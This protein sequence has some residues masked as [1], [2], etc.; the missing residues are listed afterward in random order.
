VSKNRAVPA[1]AVRGRKPSRARRALGGFYET[2]R[3]EIESE[4]SAS[5][6]GL[7]QKIDPRAKLISALLL[8]VASSSAASPTLLAGS[9]I[10]AT[11]LVVA[12]RVRGRSFLRALAAPLAI[13][14]LIILPAVL[15]LVTPGRPLVELVHL[16]KGKAIWGAP[17]PD[18]IGVTAEGTLAAARFVLRCVTCAA[19]ASALVLT[20]R[21]VSLL[22]AFR[23]LRVPR[24]FTTTM[25]MMY[26]YTFAL[27]RHAEDMRLGKESRL[28]SPE[29]ALQA[30]KVVAARI[31]RLFRTAR[32]LGD[33]VYFAMA[34]RGFSGT[35]RSLDPLSLRSL[36]FA[37]AAA[38]VIA[39]VGLILTDRMIG[40]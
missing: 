6:P 2:V 17:L 29:R 19:W 15:N 9:L 7:L 20:T 5:K 18:T 34:S 26:R 22:A 39:A 36:D 30:D 4:E 8:I 21:W 28:I 31:G 33:Q 35:A 13:S 25:I 12:S 3:R 14:S 32:R 23:A 24:I 10:A 27:I 11:L 40:R 38:A 1:A 16:G 37:V